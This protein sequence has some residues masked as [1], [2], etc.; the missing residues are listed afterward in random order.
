[1]HVSFVASV[2]TGIWTDF[3]YHHL[4]NIA[5]IHNYLLVRTILN[6]DALEVHH[7]WQCAD[8]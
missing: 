4:K 2:R 7:N 5:S 6:P 3:D 8:G 1:M